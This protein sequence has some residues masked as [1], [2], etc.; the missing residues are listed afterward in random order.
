MLCKVSLVNTVIKKKLLI[1]SKELPPE[2]GGAGIVADTIYKGL[3]QKGIDVVVSKLNKEGKILKVL[4]TFKYILLSFNFSTVLLNDL[5]FKK[6]WMILFRGRLSSRCLIYLHG[7][8]PEFLILNDKYRKLFFRLCLNSKRVVAVSHYMRQKFLASIDDKKLKSQ[9]EKKIVVI[10]NG[11]DTTLFNN[12]R[13]RSLKKSLN[14]V[15]A[16]R[17]VKEKGYLSIAK[18]L[19]RIIE[20][21]KKELIWHI[22]GAGPDEILIKNIIEAH[23]LTPY[24]KFHGALKQNELADLYNQCDVFI[25]LSEL[26]ES[27]GL[28][29]MEASCCGCYSIGFNSYGVK[30]AIIH[31]GTGNLI[32]SVDDLYDILEKVDFEPYNV[33]ELAKKTYSSSIMLQKVEQLL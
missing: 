21:S 29:Y 2:V 23:E 10:R 22:A 6:V 16:S 11:V 19:K 28:V 24:V 25:L 17:L 3:K 1:L 30:E 12:Q 15:T 9:L 14:F 33:S 26:K 5:Y 13:K 18:Q 32:N 8:E 4:I 7:S 20:V 31:K 27:L